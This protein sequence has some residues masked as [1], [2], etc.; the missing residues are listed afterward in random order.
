MYIVQLLHL[1][2]GQFHKYV[3]IKEKQVRNAIF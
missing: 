3:D 2:N 1:Y